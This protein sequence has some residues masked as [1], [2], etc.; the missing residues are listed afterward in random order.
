MDKQRVVYQEGKTWAEA[1]GFSYFET[2]SYSGQNVTEMFKTL[3][4]QII[5]VVIRNQ[6]PPN[7]PSRLG[8][9]MNK[10]TQC[11][12]SEVVQTIMRCWG[13][14]KEVASNSY[15]CVLLVMFVSYCV[16]YRDD[17]IKAYKQHAILVHPDKNLAPGS[18][19]A[20]KRITKAKDEILNS[21]R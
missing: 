19:E 4:A 7:N 6:K 12:V 21:I 15:M 17:V 9:L 18:D 5:D 16:S 10:W 2:S 14:K 13:L 20:F 8:L 3:V 11:T 1:R